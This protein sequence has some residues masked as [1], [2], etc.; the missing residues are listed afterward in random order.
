MTDALID[1]RRYIAPSVSAAARTKLE[2]LTGLVMSAP[3]SKPPQSLEEFDAAAAHAEVI[4]EYLSRAAV[5]ALSPTVVEARIG[6][7]PV[8]EVTPKDYADD[9]TVVV[10]VHG[11]GFVRN[12]A[13]SSL[14][15]AAL[16]A[17]TSGRKVVSIDYTLAPRGTCLTIVEEVVTVW[18]A[19][20]ETHDAASVG[21]MGDSAGGCIAASATHLLRDR[22]IAMP[23]ALILLSPSVDLT[24][25]GDT[26]VTLAPVDYLDRDASAS[27]LRAYVGGLAFDDPR[28]SPL[29]GDFRKGYPPALIQA[30]TREILLSDSVRLHRALRAAGIEALLDVYEGM[31]HVF[32]SLLAEAPE[33][34]AAW[35]EM[36]G[37][38][39]KH[40][41]SHP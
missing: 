22:G 21:L 40:L 31:P 39:T 2:W 16:T 18:S 5:A 38:W 23:A 20:L 27:A 6:G 4:A 19:L 14:L 34:V 25:G 9:G 41:A 7:V 24:G 11:G 37:F 10:Y 8:L 17:S 26:H 3:P 30:G 13:K 32:Q 28:V 29:F 33:G 1:L 12:S 15:M 36:T 35:S